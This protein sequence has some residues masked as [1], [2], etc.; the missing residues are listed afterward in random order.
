MKNRKI[1]QKKT[2]QVVIDAELHRRLKVK[3]SAEKTSIKTLLE[4]ALAELLEVP[5]D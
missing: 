1:D 4:G 5:H 3:A 2:K